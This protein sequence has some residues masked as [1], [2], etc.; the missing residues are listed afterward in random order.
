MLF[1]EMLLHFIKGF[2]CIS[3]SRSFMFYLPKNTTPTMLKGTQDPSAQVN[4]GQ[5]TVVFLLPGGAGDTLLSGHGATQRWNKVPFNE[6]QSPRS[7]MDVHNVSS[8]IQTLALSPLPSH[9]L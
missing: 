8:F 3:V 4:S 7:P 9:K 6:D 5:V 2:N 1:V